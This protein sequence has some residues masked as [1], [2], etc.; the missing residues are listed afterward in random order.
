MTATIVVGYIP[1][2]EGVAALLAA[3]AEAV[4]RGARVVVVNTGHHGDYS[5]PVFAQPADLDAIDK[6]LNDAGIAHEVRQPTSGT[7]AAEE[8]LAAA[9][10]SHADLIVVGM[11]RRSPV[12]KMLLGSTSQEVL[13]D[14]PCPVLAVKPKAT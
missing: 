13:L 11:R 1:T 6:E 10:A 5:D 2:P 12:G 8:L 14:A 3:K 9:E 4:L 7:S